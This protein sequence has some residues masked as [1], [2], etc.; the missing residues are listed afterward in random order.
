M[1]T[2]DSAPAA[3][4][5]FDDG[6]PEADRPADPPLAAARR[7]DD[8]GVEADRLAADPT[9]A[10]AR[11]LDA[12]LPTADRRVPSLLMLPI[13]ERLRLLADGSLDRDE[14][15]SAAD[16]WAR[17]ADTRYR[18]CTQL[19][20]GHPDLP[21]L[22][23]GVKDTIDIAG[24]ATTLGLRR[25]RHH[26]THDAAAARGLRELD[27]VA[28]LVTT[29]VNIGIGSGCTNPAFPRIDPAGSS[30]GCGVAV[31]AAICDLAL[32]TDVLG[33]VR[34]PAGRCGM[35]GLR[36]THDPTAMTGVFP[37]SPAMDA[38]GWV[39]RSADDLLILAAHAGLPFGRAAAARYAASPGSAGKYAASPG[40]AVTARP[41]D[42]AGSAG[43]GR[44]ADL[45]G[46][47]AVAAVF[48]NAAEP[49][50]APRRR[51][52]IVA[53]VASGQGADPEI[54]SALKLTA[55]LLTE[56]GHT[57]TE[58]PIGDL[59]QHRATA[60]D[61][62]AREA[63]NGFQTWQTHLADPSDL[64]D[65]TR[66]ALES[67]ARISDHRYAQAR[68][69]LAA[70]RSSTTALFANVDA[71]LL[72]LDP[73]VPAPRDARPRAASS[74]VTPDHPDYDRE[75]GYTPLASFAGLP[76]VTF[77]VAIH[78]PWQAPLA[79]QLLG[80]PG[81]EADLLELVRELELVRGPL[82]V[83]P[84]WGLKVKV[85]S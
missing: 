52:G 14:W 3:A 11:Y 28:K 47:A 16:E 81:A 78:Q 54:L 51:I 75:V 6:R 17:V 34:W 15:A 20:D 44:P 56:S 36:M 59:W 39:A 77:P 55:D 85:K 73:D 49:I 46:L 8:R 80:P 25:H 26:P 35:V 70:T 63:W 82:D 18:A 30:T 7:F 24:F 12:A 33:S 32:G 58:R 21:P 84:R 57:M 64:S 42:F 68:T 60:W 2:A 5:R 72:P 48:A 66:R 83:S 27:I 69:A 65:S 4:R 38:P 74:L 19:R 43:T 62:C 71:W 50:R 53:E 1:P 10:A 67:G 37:L 9:L 76:A 31:A 61:L 40:S 45:A 29:E 13:R 23:V 79:M 22:R 41:A